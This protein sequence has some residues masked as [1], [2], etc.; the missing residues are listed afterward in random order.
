MKREQNWGLKER[1]K[2]KEIKIVYNDKILVDTTEMP[3]I[4]HERFII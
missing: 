4:D 1:I 2:V 3:L